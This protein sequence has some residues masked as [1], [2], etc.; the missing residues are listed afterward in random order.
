MG[1]IAP[2]G[3]VAKIGFAA[4]ARAGHKAIFTG[5]DCIQGSHPQPGCDIHK[6]SLIDLRGNR[7]GGKLRLPHGGQIHGSGFN[8]KLLRQRVAVIRVHAK[9]ARRGTGHDDAHGV[10]TGCLAENAHKCA[11]LAAGIAEHD[12][13]GMTFRQRLPDKGHPVF[14][15]FLVISH[16]TSSNAA[17]TNPTNNGW[18]LL[19]RL[20]NSGWYCTP[21]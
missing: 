7:E 15:F 3:K 20:L 4:V 9:V 13:G 10:V 21:T 8:V 19:G 5:G 11:V 16:F 2:L 18:G 1:T 17:F 14:K 6:G 12:P